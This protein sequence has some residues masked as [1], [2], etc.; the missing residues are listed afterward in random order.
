M[1][2]LRRQSAARA[3]S[4]GTGRPVS[5]AGPPPRAAPGS[6]AS[7]LSL[8]GPAQRPSH[9]APGRAG[10]F[11]PRPLS[12]VQPRLRAAKARVLASHPARPAAPPGRP[13]PPPHLGGLPPPGISRAA[14]A[15]PPGPGGSSL[16]P[17]SAG[18]PSSQSGHRTGP[19]G[20]VG[21]H[22]GWSVANVLWG[23]PSDSLSSHRRVESKMGCPLEAIWRREGEAQRRRRCV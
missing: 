20:V 18:S 7:L 17:H 11:L 6:S 16:G 15:L 10:S 3:G 23:R 4:Q 2:T 19:G 9:Q 14:P 8:G 13:G 12:C 5:P 1:H 21:G 22:A